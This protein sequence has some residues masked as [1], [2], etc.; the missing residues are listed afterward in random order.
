M[1]LSKILARLGCFRPIHIVN[2]LI[3]LLNFATFDLFS[4]NSVIQWRIELCCGCCCLWQ[5]QHPR[6]SVGA[7][8][9]FAVD[10]P[11]SMQYSTKY[12]SRP[13]A[14]M[15][16]GGRH[17]TVTVLSVTSSTTSMV[18]SLVTA[19]RRSEAFDFQQ[20]RRSE[21]IH[22]GE[23]QAQEQGVSLSQAGMLS[24]SLSDLISPCS[25]RLF[26]CSESYLTP[27]EPPG[28]TWSPKPLIHR[29]FGSH[30]KDIFN[31]LQSSCVSS[32][33]HSQ[34]AWDGGYGA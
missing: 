22:F 15:V 27:I 18:G 21:N 2:H 4:Y 32:G 25:C 23:S 30:Y 33:G 29:W 16:S 7:Y 11:P 9:S 26:L 12:P 8:N 10:S 14:P 1:F 19:E 24:I 31:I 3:M 34:N 28:Q 5:T 13:A 17:F 20:W 6:A